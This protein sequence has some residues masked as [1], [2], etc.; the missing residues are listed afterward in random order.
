MD[1]YFE[2]RHAL[3]FLLPGRFSTTHQTIGLE[4]TNLS[5][6]EASYCFVFQTASLIRFAKVTMSSLFVN[7]VILFDNR[8]YK[9]RAFSWPCFLL[10]SK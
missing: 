9:E 5:C 7:D 1:H 8:R 10:H 2:M 3:T 4:E 6:P